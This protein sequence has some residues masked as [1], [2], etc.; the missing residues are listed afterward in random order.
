[1]R[2]RIAQGVRQRAQVHPAG[3]VQ[4]CRTMKRREVQLRAGIVGTALSACPQVSA[5]CKHGVEEWL[6]HVQGRWWQSCKRRHATHRCGATKCLTWPRLLPPSESNRFFLFFASP[7]PA[8]EEPLGD[9]AG[10]TLAHRSH[11]RQFAMTL[12]CIA[13]MAATSE[14]CA[15]TRAWLASG[16]GLEWKDQH[17]EHDVA[18]RGPLH[19]AP[20]L[21][22]LPPIPAQL[23]PLKAR[24]CCKAFVGI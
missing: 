1:M 3:E 23:P 19:F 10:H 18:H 15:W 16:H 14:I 24:L 12:T 20:A 8:I 9:A 13:P 6:L 7:S 22:Q 11:M 17:S 21:T 2:A 5:A 4:R